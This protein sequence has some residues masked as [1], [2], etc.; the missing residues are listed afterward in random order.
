MKKK[1]LLLNLATVAVAGM[2]LQACSKDSKNNGIDINPQSGVGAA[3]VGSPKNGP[4]SVCYVEVNNNNLLNVGSYTLKSGKQQLFD[5]A[6]I[7]AS[8]INYDPATKKAV[9]FHNENVTKVLNGKNTYIKPLQDKGIKV[10][11]TILGNHQGTGF[12]NFTSRADAKAFAQ[13]LSN[14]VTTY[15]LDGIDFDDEYSEYGKNNTPQP[16]DSSFVMLVQELRKLIPNKLITFYYL[17]PVTSRLTWNGQ[18]ALDHINY[19]WNPW[20]GTFDVNS[21]PALPKSQ[22]SPAA[23]WIGNNSEA[24]AKSLAQKTVDQGYGVFMTYDLN[25]VDRTSYLTSVARILYKDDVVLTSPLLPK[26]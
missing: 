16:N 25:N 2:L 20:Y 26:P 14:A 15:N 1:T 8:N 12:A 21:V 18:K 23:L 6:A 11:L 7:F 3:A 4:V 22:V 13:Q 19:G 10:L 9:L 24:T 5:I 17:G